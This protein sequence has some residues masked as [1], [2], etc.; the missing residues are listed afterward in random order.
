MEALGVFLDEIQKTVPEEVGKAKNI[1]AKL[2]VLCEVLEHV[3]D[4]VL[5]DEVGLEMWEKEIEDLI[6][7]L[8]LI[9]RIEGK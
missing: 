9:P 5:E 1:K 8:E 3:K 4:G 6:K 2:D 7:K